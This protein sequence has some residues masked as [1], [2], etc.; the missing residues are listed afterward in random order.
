MCSLAYL[1]V[2]GLFRYSYEGIVSAERKLFFLGMLAEEMYGY[3]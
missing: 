1:T 2:S 3:D